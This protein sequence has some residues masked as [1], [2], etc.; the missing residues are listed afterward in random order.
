VVLLCVTTT[1]IVKS[2]QGTE[3]IHPLFYRNRVRSSQLPP[4]ESSKKSPLPS[5]V[6]LYY[7]T[8]Y[9]DASSS[10]IPMTR[11]HANVDSAPPPTSTKIIDIHHHV[12]LD[13]QKKAKKN[14]LVGWVTPPENLPWQPSTAISDM[15]A[16]GIQ[17]A[18]LSPP[19][20]ATTDRT[21]VRA[22]NIHLS[23]LC[24]AHPTRFGCLAGLPT[25][26]DVQGSVA[27]QPSQG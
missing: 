13:A 9:R 6:P 4:K 24:A 16:M 3:S 25:L 27:L 20:V 8:S 5:T 10:I 21:E 18:I 12:F 1:N 19:P 26:S 15:D 7:F 17:T 2:L 22:M 14:M 11:I 23:R